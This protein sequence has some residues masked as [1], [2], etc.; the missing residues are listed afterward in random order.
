MWHPVRPAHRHP[1]GVPAPGARP[2]LGHDL[3]APPGGLERGRRLGPV[4]PVAAE[5]NAVEEPA[6]LVPGGD[7][8]SSWLRRG[9]PHPRP[10]R[11]QGP[12][13]GPG[14]VDRARPGSEHHLVTD[15]QGIP[16]AVSLTGGNRHD[17]TQLL[18]LLE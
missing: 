4:P 2:R 9:H 18:P 8:L 3:P 11:T 6:G 12:Q 1:G 5:Q 13:S 16:L 15:G 17:V 10:G 14:P 7:R